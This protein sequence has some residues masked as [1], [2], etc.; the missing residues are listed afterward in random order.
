MLN[1]VSPE[2]ARLIQAEREREIAEDRLAG[3]V[4]AARARCRTAGRGTVRLLR[5][6]SF[7]SP[8]PC[9]C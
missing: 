9:C 4:R 7:R 6:L 3:A 1:Y 2:V 5:A 8:S